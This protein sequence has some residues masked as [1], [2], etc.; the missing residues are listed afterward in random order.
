LGTAVLRC[1]AEKKYRQERERPVQTGVRVDLQKQAQ[2]AI[3]DHASEIKD[4]AAQIHDHPETAWKEERA[5]KLMVD[6]L[7]RHGFDVEFPVGGVATA[8]RATKRGKG[9][10]P[11]IAILAEYDALPNIGHGCAHNFIASSALA[12]AIALGPLMDQLDGTLQIIGTP[13]EEAGGGKI[14][15]IDA[16]IFKG[17]DAALM[18]HHAGDRTGAATQYPAGTCLAISHLLFEFHGASAHAAGDPWNGANAL[19]GVIKL[20][21]GIDA[22]RQHIKPDARIHGII[23]HGGDAPNVVPHYAAAEFYV[24]GPDL[25]YVKTLED[26]LRKIAEGAALMTETTVEVKSPF[27]TY[28]DERPSYVVGKRYRQHMSEV[29]MEL[30]PEATQRG[31]YSTDFGNVSYLMPAVTGSFAISRTPIPGHSPAVVAAACSDYGYEQMFKV[32]KAMALTAL[33]L[34]SEPE[35]LAAA[36]DEHD[37]W[38]ERYE[39]TR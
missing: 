29:G 35:L 14:A 27:A 19:N 32:S 9:A 3:D 25:A 4:V 20:F 6:A 31:S 23:T 10:G 39:S 26:K 15:L 12:T 21:T 30:T 13:A 16:G 33:D 17:V 1:I 2:M 22:L 37:H 28:Y 36:K 34:F 24:R 11:T 18:V 7:K 38:S 8:F 5:S